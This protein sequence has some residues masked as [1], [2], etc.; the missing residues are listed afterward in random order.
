VSEP[1]SPLPDSYEGMRNRSL[2]A[3]QAGDVENAVALHRRLVEKLGRLSHGVLARRPELRDME[4]Q[5]RLELAEMLRLEGHFSEAIEVKEVLLESHPDRASDW[6]RDLAILRITRGEVETG[7]AELRTLAE[8]DPEDTWRWI[9]LGV[10]S[11]LEG[12]FAESQEALDRALV[13]AQDSG[14]TDELTT[15]HYHCFLLYREMG[16][17]DDAV[18][19]WNEALDL[20]AEVGSTVRDVY[21]ML[22]DAGRFSEAR[23]YVD[24]DDNEL[25]AG[26]QRGLLA[27][28]TGSAADAKREWRAVAELDPEDFESGHDA[29]AEAVLRLGDPEPVLERM[30]SLL[31]RHGSARLLTFAGIAWAMRGDRQEAQQAFERTIDILR[32]SR[33]PRHKLDSADWRLLDL[34]VADEELKPVLKPYFAV[35]ETV[36]G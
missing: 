1:R 26:Y 12:R 18:A 2:T 32:T 4:L 28:L 16:R 21:T 33:P 13:L 22:T 19:A 24:R 15:A 23:S 27:H 20:N 10:E 30:N 6:R 34:L 8:E 7:L 5:A 3:F 9:V 11:R 31:G 17:L 14:D 35:V 36:W 29:W 25:R